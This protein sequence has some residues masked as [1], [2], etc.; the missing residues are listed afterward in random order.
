MATIKIKIKVKSEDESKLPDW[1]LGK[2]ILAERTVTLGEE[3]TESN[4]IRYQMMLDEQYQ[5]L[6]DETVERTITID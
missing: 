4:K 5:I 3:V 6:L 2:G 1:G